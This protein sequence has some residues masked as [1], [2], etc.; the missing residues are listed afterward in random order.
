MA[1]G[2]NLWAGAAHWKFG[3]RDQPKRQLNNTTL[4]S[5][6]D[7]FGGAEGSA[8]AGGSG[9][10]PAKKQRKAGKSLV[11]VDFVPLPD[12]DDEA[13]VVS[14]IAVLVA[15]P[16]AKTSSSKG[17]AATSA[18]AAKKA[19]AAAATQL[20]AAAVAKTEGAAAAASYSLPE[21]A[22]V[23]PGD[24]ARLFLRPAARVGMGAAA[25]DY[26]T[27]SSS[28]SSSSSSPPWGFVEEAT[29]ANAGRATS[30]LG[31]AH[32]YDDDGGFEGSKYDAGCDDDSFGDDDACGT[33]FHMA[34]GS[35]RAE[36]YT[37]GGDEDFDSRRMLA[38][39]R[40]VEKIHVRHA[41]AS[42]KVDVKELKH[43][44]WNDLS[45]LSAKAEAGAADAGA[46]AASSAGGA[47]TTSFEEVVANVEAEQNDQE[48]V[49][50]SYYFI[51]VLHLAN[52][53][54]LKLEGMEDLSNF[55]ISAT[56]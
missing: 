1:G 26:S 45:K 43:M 2:G 9:A 34:A 20:S 6:A 37:D 27:P 15:A 35:P 13:A 48:G 30:G 3:K 29:F 19:T 38:P 33:G 24:L 28:S 4:A 55:T 53:H 8:V 40:K 49:T 16:N 44:I 23:R 50:C 41:T 14:R 25:S 56:E 39:D 21:D 52:E 31:G 7:T 18:A 42:K 54:G 11:S 47:S 10:A 46:D 12:A 51:C 22:C 17:K 5:D 36:D 32:G